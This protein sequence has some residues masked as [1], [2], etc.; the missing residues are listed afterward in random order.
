M[1][2]IGN[3]IVEGIKLYSCWV[4]QGTGEHEWVDQAHA[5]DCNE[6]CC[7][8]C[9]VQIRQAAPCVDCQGSGLV[10]YEKLKQQL[11][12]EIKDNLVA[13]DILEHYK[14]EACQRYSQKP[15]VVT[16]LKD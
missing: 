5:E 16:Q 9:P 4:C 14:E 7:S 12:H 2:S 8:S 1:N 13:I 10:T 6:N 11:V 3:T 15:M